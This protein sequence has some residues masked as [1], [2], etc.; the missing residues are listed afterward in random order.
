MRRITFLVAT[1]LT[2]LLSLSAAP[3]SAAPLGASFVA[4][5]ENVTPVADLYAAP[6]RAYYEEEYVAPRR[7]GYEYAPPPRRYGY[8]YAPPRR[9]EYYVEEEYV[10]VPRP[11]A[12]VYSQLGPYYHPY[13]YYRPYYLP[14]YRRPYYGDAW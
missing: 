7:Y 12:R 5:P 6:P 14:G 4:A 2:A 10:P 8:E 1:S 9:Y 11:P 13:Y 3:A